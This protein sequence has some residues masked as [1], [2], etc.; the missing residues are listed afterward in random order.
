MPWDPTSVRVGLAAAAHLICNGYEPTGVVKHDDGK[1]KVRFPASA[2]LIAAVARYQTVI[3]NIKARA[4][5]ATPA[6]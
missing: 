3:D 4:D 5:R 2:D 6:L 1:I